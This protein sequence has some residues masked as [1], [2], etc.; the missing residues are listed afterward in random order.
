MAS[1][2]WEKRLQRI[3][4]D[5]QKGGRVIARGNGHAG[6]PELHHMIRP[7]F[8]MNGGHFVSENYCFGAPSIWGMNARLVQTVADFRP[9]LRNRLRA[10]GYHRTRTERA[11]TRFRSFQHG[12]PPLGEAFYC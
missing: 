2:A 9:R 11:R 10:R 12:I 5:E 1:G 6:S 8:E 3:S 7:R 4:A